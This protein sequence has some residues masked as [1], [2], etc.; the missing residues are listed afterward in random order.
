VDAVNR[1]VAIAGALLVAL[2]VGLWL[3]SRNA[4]VPGAGTGSR[5]RPSPSQRT[6]AQPVKQVRPAAAQAE[7]V[8]APPPEEAKPQGVLA[9]ELIAGDSPVPAAQVQLYWREPAEGSA[10]LA[11]WRQVS[12]GETDGSGR[13]EA[14]ARPG[15]YF[16][17]ARAEGFAPATTG[18]VHPP[19]GARTPVRLRLET[20]VELQGTTVVRGDGEPVSLA[21]IILTPLAFPPDLRGHLDAPE[22]E[23]LFATSSETGEFRFTGLAPG[24]YRAEA[25]APG[26]VRKVLPSVPAPFGGSIT[27]DLA[28]GGLIEGAVTGADGQPVAG[29]E[30]LAFNTAHATQ[31]FTNGQGHFSLE[32][33]PGTYFVSARREPLAGE[34]GH[35]VTVT[36]EHSVR[37]L[38]L[39]LGAGAHV[40]GTVVTEEGAAVMGARVEAR[41]RRARAPSGLVGTDERGAFSLP[42]LAPG[43]YEV[44]VFMPHGGSFTHE[45]LT[46]S[47]GEHAMLTLTY[48][49]RGSLKVS[50]TDMKRRRLPGVHVRAYAIPEQR[51]AASASHEGQTDAHGAVF[52]KG[53]LPGLYRVEV[54]REPGSPALERTATVWENGLAELA[55]RV[56]GPD[57]DPSLASTVEGRVI[58]RSGA[59]PEAPVQIEAITRGPKSRTLQA[60]P[61]DAQGHFRMV[62]PP[63]PYTLAARLQRRLHCEADG[64]T[65]V[66]LE[67]AQHTQATVLLEEPRAPVLRLR[68]QEAD[69]AASRLT[70]V[71]VHT[72]TWNASGQT[73]ASGLLELCGPLKV[74]PDAPLLVQVHGQRRAALVTQASGQQELTAQLRPLPVLRGRVIH[75]SGLPVR[76][77]HVDVVSRD[78]SLSHS[79]HDFL[80]DQFE[81]H[82]VPLGRSQLFVTV[83]DG[84]RA[85]ADVSMSPGA[86]ARLEIPVHPGVPLT[87]RIVDATTGAPMPEAQVVIW[88]FAHTLT[89]RDGRFTIRD[90]PAGE[91]ELQF[92]RGLARDSRTVTLV[93]GQAHDLG[94]LALAPP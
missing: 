61:A 38:L 53:L 50:A 70:P 17:A 16:V 93:P 92:S 20:G 94:D 33:P 52:L 32:V 22:E 34:L 83:D 14:P 86:D 71:R 18:V 46:L 12:G 91:H 45:G 58:Q 10:P 81:L 82:E 35:Q 7:Q 36:V 57:D 27:L 25:R 79:A 29:A 43:T 39:Q 2:G 65:E 40:S 72:R 28:P 60:V 85:M 54:Q 90:L 74:A 78:F 63:G 80:G 73:D 75:T 76:R 64:Q 88:L 6:R 24:R 37:G 67:A 55:V 3:F 30:V 89:A 8:E 84:R 4:P 68:V 26:F 42:S 56:T 48:K 11:R 87:G 69:G 1:R 77:F 59:P 15:S 41:S 19:G 66:Q 23:L 13:W 47:E 9:V 62:L 44:S 51:G 5:T 21:E 31:G 49:P